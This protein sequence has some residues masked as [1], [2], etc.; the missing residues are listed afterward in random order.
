MTDRWGHQRVGIA[1][2]MAATVWPL[3][4]VSAAEPIF[5]KADILDVV[6]E[7]PLDRLQGVSSGGETVAGVIELDGEHIPVGLTTYGISRLEEC[8]SPSLKIELDPETT[9]GTPF[10]GHR[11]VRMVRPCHRGPSFDRS[12]AMVA[13][14]AL[15]TRL[16]RCR[17][18]D[19]QR[20]SAEHARLAFFLED[21]GE[22]AA[23]NGLAWLDIE[24]LSVG[25]LDPD[26]VALLTLFQYMVGNTDW[27]ALM[28][29]PGER[30]CHNMA[31][32]GV[33]AG[34]G[35]PSLLPFDFDFAGIV[36]APYALPDQQ[37]P[38]QRVTQ[39]IY[40]GFCAHN[41]RLP[42]AIEHLNRLRPQLE[43]LYADDRLPSPKAR[44]RAL[45][46]I[47]SFYD[48]IND[49]QSVQRKILRHCR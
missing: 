31:V 44:Q 9:A 39:R 20:P 38:I 32:L 35:R 4:A 7:A 18:R 23:R 25:D 8:G 27:S 49:P 15:R 47:E 28:S 42:A 45:K 3:C 26:Q 11:C 6:I 5:G 41:D 36:N 16:A 12:Y 14:P 2:L 21:I 1:A 33:E 48:T 46:Y 13:G 37:I 29:S 22:A 34:D 10:E 17:F 43:A 30:C 40:R 19:A 24:V